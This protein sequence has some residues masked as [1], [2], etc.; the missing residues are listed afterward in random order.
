MHVGAVL[1][2]T[3][4]MGGV[5]LM[6]AQTDVVTDIASLAGLSTVVGILVVCGTMLV[7]LVKL[8][9]GQVPQ[10][11]FQACEDYVDLLQNHC[12]ENGL[13]IPPRQR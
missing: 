8:T 13:P 10:S 9:T 3:G 12:L 5:P 11:E 7:R 2:V 4:A 6:L 1:A